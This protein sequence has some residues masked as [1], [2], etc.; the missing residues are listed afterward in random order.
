METTAGVSAGLTGG[1]LEFNP[2]SPD[3]QAA[4]PTIGCGPPRPCTGSIY[5][6]PSFPA[7]GS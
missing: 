4:P 6:C 2:F 3:F 7:S 5:R 1:V